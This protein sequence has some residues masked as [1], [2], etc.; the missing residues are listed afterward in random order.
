MASPGCH[1]PG[2]CKRTPC[3]GGCAPGE[4]VPSAAAS[5]RVRVTGG[6]LR[7]T[8]RAMAARSARTR[9]EESRSTEEEERLLTK[10]CIERQ[11]KNTW[12][13]LFER[14]KAQNR[15]IYRPRQ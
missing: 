1:Q 13:T 5:W 15:N 3:G 9:E 12:E 8:D 11:W 14:E 2:R 7:P 6:K 10:R 4:H